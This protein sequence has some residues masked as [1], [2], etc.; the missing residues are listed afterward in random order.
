MVFDTIS[1]NTGHKTA[2]CVAAQKSLKKELSCFA[3]RHHIGDV[4]L[5]DVWEALKVEVGK[6]PE[7]TVF[8]KFKENFDKLTHL[9]ISGLNFLLIDKQ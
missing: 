8:K 2:G 3:C 9:D 4:L 6:K 5:K 1:A 7:V